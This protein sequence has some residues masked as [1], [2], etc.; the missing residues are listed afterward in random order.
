MKSIYLTI[1]LNA[2]VSRFQSTREGNYSVGAGY[3]VLNNLPRHLQFL[4]ENI[5]LVLI[6][7]GPKEP[8]DYALDQMLSPLIEELLELKQGEIHSSLTHLR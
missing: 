8:T 5:C 4:R 2:R 1:I 6:M 3:I 7:P